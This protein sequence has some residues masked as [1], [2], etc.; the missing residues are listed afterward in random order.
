[1]PSNS[2]L[3]KVYFLAICLG[4]FIFSSVI[5]HAGEVVFETT[6]PWYYSWLSMGWGTGSITGTSEMSIRYTPSLNQEVCTI[7]PGLYKVGNPTDY[8]ILT[9]KAG[10]NGYPPS[11]SVIRTA[12]VSGDQVA[13]PPVIGNQSTYTAFTFSPCLN[14]VANTNYS[15]V[16]SR[17]QLP[18][19]NTPD[20][21]NLY[22]LQ[23]SNLA[24]YPQTAVWAYVPIN[25]YWQELYNY[26]PALR[27]EGPDTKEPVI[28]VPGILGSRL[29]RVSDGEE[30]WPSIGL[31]AIPGPDDYLNDLKLDES[32]NEVLDINS[33]EIIESVLSF[34][35]YGDLIQKFKDN[36]YKLG[37]DLFVVPYDWRLDVEVSSLDLDSVVNVA[38]A[39]SPT[40]KVNFIAH[41]MGGLLIKDYL[42]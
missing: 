34:N 3:R 33:S 5:A 25:Y 13:N 24:Y 12:T 19:Y 32:G 6:L 36:G 17:T 11:G 2:T 28:I 37:R 27:L 15:F 40:G 26:E 4:L 42:M 14:L 29:N 21:H 35:Q 38:I 10:G 1:M 8:V 31:M 7:K 18:S 22:A 30:V 41:S 23:I 9:V 20:L 39:N 16:F